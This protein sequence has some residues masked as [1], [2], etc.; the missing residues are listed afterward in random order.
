MESTQEDTLKGN[1]VLR[2]VYQ[3]V[4]VLEMRQQLWI[5]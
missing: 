4:I 5:F 2:R 1:V 3:Y